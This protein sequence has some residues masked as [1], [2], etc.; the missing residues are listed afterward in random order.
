MLAVAKG[1]RRFSWD[2]ISCSREYVCIKG[3][4]YPLGTLMAVVGR[5]SLLSLATVQ[6]QQQL[7]EQWL[8]SSPVETDLRLLAGSRLEKSQQCAVAAKRTNR[9]LGCIKQ[10][11]RKT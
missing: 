2:G 11:S 3:F 1:I 4:R 7:G 8:G 9:M 6:S 5:G 10:A